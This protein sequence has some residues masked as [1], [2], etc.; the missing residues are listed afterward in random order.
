MQ[1]VIVL[2]EQRE[3]PCKAGPAGGIRA[4]QDERVTLVG[5]QLSSGCHQPG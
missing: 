5:G 3:C 2:E 1:I 4:K